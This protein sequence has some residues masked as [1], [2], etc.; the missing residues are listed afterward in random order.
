MSPF[1]IHAV[2]KHSRATNARV[3]L[4]KLLDV[5]G[6]VGISPFNIHAVAKHNCATNARVKLRKLL[7]VY[8]DSTGTAYSV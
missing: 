5:Y 6:S 2:A 8:K 4:R 1:N 7:D 3:K